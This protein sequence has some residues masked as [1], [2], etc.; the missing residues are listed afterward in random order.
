M[1]PEVLKRATEPFFTTKPGRSGIGLSVAHGIWRRHR[2]AL[3]IVSAPGEG[4]TIRLAVEA[5]A[6]ASAA[7]SET[8][9]LRI[10]PSVASEY[11]PARPEE[12]VAETASDPPEASPEPWRPS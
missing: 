6:P 11:T 10:E 4:T 2:G 8:P 9:R 7:A 3:S 5:H 12:P 1:T